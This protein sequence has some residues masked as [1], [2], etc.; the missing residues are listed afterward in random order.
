MARSGRVDYLDGIRALAIACVLA[1]HWFSW[2]T[3][4]FHGGAIGVDIFFVLSGFIITTMLWRAPR[5]GTGWATWWSFLGRRVARLYPALLGLVV[6]CVV[7]YAVVPWAP[8]EPAEVARRGALVL[9]QGGAVWASARHGSFW[10]PGLQPFGQTWSLAVEWYFYLLWPLVV[11]G[12]RA[13]SWS[14]RRLA[15]ASVW[16]AAAAY[17]VSLALPDFPFYF[18]PLARSAELLVGGALALSF[19]ASDRPARP[20]RHATPVA[21]AALAAVALYTVLG[22]DGHDPLYRLVGIPAAV[23]ATV[24]LIHTGRARHDDGR[25]GVV[26]RLLGHPWP[27]AVGRYSYSLYLWHIVPFL[28]LERASGG[29]PK[30]VLGL[31]AVSAAVCLTVLSHRLLERPFLRPHSTL[32]AAPPAA[33][34]AAVAHEP[35][36]A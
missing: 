32:L 20:W 8:I 34:V 21:V 15:L 27:A 16:F 19:L 2:Y 29:L 12:V 6:G 14:P 30:P 23:V 3:P 9:V 36:Q 22:S 18:G 10:L 35:T 17:A 5:A 11:I 33:P 7:L 4:F 1:L 26:H 13:R 31:A 28:L 24:V 25:A